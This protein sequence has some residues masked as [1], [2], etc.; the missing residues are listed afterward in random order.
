[1]LLLE[2]RNSP[3]FCFFAND[4]ASR[5]P[6]LNRGL[7]TNEPKI[8]IDP[9]LRK[10]LKVGSS[11]VKWA[12]TPCDPWTLIPNPHASM[13][14]SSGIPLTRRIESRS[15]RAGDAIVLRT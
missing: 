13:P 1:M 8:F 10:W 9:F 5:A 7:G 3:G 2:T 12:I 15:H 6:N 14:E 4:G 11:G